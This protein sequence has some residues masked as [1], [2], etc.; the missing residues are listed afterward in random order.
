MQNDTGKQSDSLNQS[1]TPDELLKLI[2]EWFGLD[3][4]DLCQDCFEEWCNDEFWKAVDE[5]SL[6]VAE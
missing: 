5:G 1:E 3:V 4:D 6:K 2:A